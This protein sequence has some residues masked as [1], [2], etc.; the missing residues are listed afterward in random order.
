MSDWEVVKEPTESKPPMPESDW[1][2]VQA[3]PESPR[4]KETLG[5]SA[6]AAPG[7]MIED[8][9]RSMMDTVRSSPQLW[10]KAKTEIPGLANMAAKPLAGAGA[11]MML[12]GAP[13]SSM[14]NLFNGSLNGEPT[15]MK[16]VGGQVVAGLGEMGKEAFNL[17]HNV[18]NYATE[19]L[20]LFPEDINKKIQMG[21]MPDEE[22]QQAIN[23]RFGE[24]K[25]PGEALIRWASAHAIPITGAGAAAMAL[26]PMRLTATNIAHEVVR[27]G[28]RQVATH[29]ALYNRLWRDA[30][31]AGMNHVPFDR[32]LVQNNYEF[33]DQYKTPKETESLV[34]LM[35]HPT[36]RNAQ[37]A[38]SDLRG[39]QRSL[40]EK[41]KKGALFSE[42]RQTLD[43]AIQ[44]ERH[45]VDNMFLNQ[46]GTVNHRL[47]NRYRGISESYAENVV[48]YR[49]N[50]D[51]QEFKDRGITAKQ[52]V[53]RLP[54]NEFGAK[55]AH[56]HPNLYRREAMLKAL[57]SINNV[58]VGIA[59]GAVGAGLTGYGMY[60]YMSGKP[61]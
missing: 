48:P 27:E 13:V 50:A 58:A 26:N 29:N 14:S 42:E 55:K 28:E 39:I 32:N 56:L 43:A 52:L 6:A 51:I 2:K 34:N 54:I 17:P 41:S 3:A 61:Q 44:T 25:L 1:E 37:T 20:H 46:D 49:Y 24:P 60:K 16:Q 11:S 10:E 53:D 4:S 23:Q 35:A 18:A 31:R 7:R 5:F 45:I 36:L 21:R 57:S 22:T 40:E 33:I 19:R 38:V 8:F 47:A 9:Y 30:D 59:G 12:G 15:N